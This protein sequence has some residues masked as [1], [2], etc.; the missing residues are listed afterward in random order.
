LPQKT[1]FTTKAL[2]PE[3]TKTKTK[4]ELSFKAERTLLN[5][6]A[7]L[8]EYIKGETDGI[9][10][11]P[12]F[13]TEAKLIGAIVSDYVVLRNKVNIGLSK[14]TLEEKFGEAKIS[15]DD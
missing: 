7:V 14:R 15:L 8:L 2:L 5:I 4:K 9:E 6:I 10:K 1:K 11:H 12:S 13:T 3:D